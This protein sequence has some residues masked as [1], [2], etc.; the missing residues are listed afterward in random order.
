MDMCLIIVNSIDVVE[1]FIGKKLCGYCVLMY[2][3]CEIIVK[4]FCEYEFFYDLFFMY[5]DF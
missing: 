4:F 1:K 3:I 5:Y 2:I